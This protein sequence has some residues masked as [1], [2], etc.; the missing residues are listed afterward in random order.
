M[1]EELK[2]VVNRFKTFLIASFYLKQK[3]QF[4]SLLTFFFHSKPKNIKKLTDFK[5]KSVQF[6]VLAE[7]VDAKT[8]EKKAT[9]KTSN[10]TI[11]T[12]FIFNSSTISSDKL[13]ILFYTLKIF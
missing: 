13:Y 2:I 12:T 1:V 11:H 7:S 8:S 5:S 9:D 10:K 6:G 3:K 4:V